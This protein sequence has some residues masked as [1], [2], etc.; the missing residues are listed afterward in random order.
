MEPITTTAAPGAP[1][2]VNDVAPPA[3][4]M[5]APQPAPVPPASAPAPPAPAPSTPPAD[6]QAV[7]VE[8]IPVKTQQ[9]TSQIIPGGLNPVDAPINPLSAPVPSPEA[10]PQPTAG[11][12]SHSEL[13]HSR[14]HAVMNVPK[15]SM[16]LLAIVLALTVAAV[17]GAA[18]Y[19]AFA[20]A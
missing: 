20:G 16:H 13:L 19:F 7:K 15:P 9:D 17:L 4:G 18:A 3:A 11:P 6:S 14:N 12:N 5:P 2:L 1:R 8:N 10:P